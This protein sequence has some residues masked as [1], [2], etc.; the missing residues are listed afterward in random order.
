MLWGTVL[1]IWWHISYNL[2]TAFQTIFDNHLQHHQGLSC[3]S[4]RNPASATR[5][6]SFFR[7]I[8]HEINVQWHQLQLPV[9]LPGHWCQ[10]MVSG[11]ARSSCG[12]SVAV[13]W[14]DSCSDTHDGDCSVWNTH[15]R[16]LGDHQRIPKRDLANRLFSP[17]QSILRWKVN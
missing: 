1:L 4:R 5:L 7:R 14:H 16:S 10:E 17:C 6:Y 8:V 11:F 13:L 12:F 2:G 3:C 15:L 9:S